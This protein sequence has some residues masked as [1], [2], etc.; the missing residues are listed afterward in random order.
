MVADEYQHH[1]IGSLL[2][3]ELASAAR[4]HGISTFV[5]DTLDENHTM[6]GVFTHSGFPITRQSEFG[7]VSLRFPIASTRSYREA[8]TGRRAG[9]HIAPHGATLSPEQEPLESDG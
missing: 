9:W 7:T 2:L 3:D 8:V 6:L 1:G 5:A 4:A